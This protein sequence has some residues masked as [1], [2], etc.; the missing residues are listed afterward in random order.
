MRALSVV[1]LGLEDLLLLLS[2]LSFQ[3][4]SSLFV[5]DVVL[6]LE[7]V[8]LE[9]LE[10]WIVQSRLHVERQRNIFEYIS[11]HCLVIVLHIEEQGLL[12][13][14]MEIIFYFVV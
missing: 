7:I 11:T 2:L 1:R 4:G 6:K 12:V 14:D 5:L 3:L 8:M 10:F 9:S 13:V